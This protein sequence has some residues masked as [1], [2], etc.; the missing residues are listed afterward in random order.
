M[1][2]ESAELEVVAVGPIKV[3]IVPGIVTEPI[4]AT[5]RAGKYENARQ[6]CLRPMVEDGDRIVDIGG[7]IGFISTLMALEGRAERIVSIEGHPGAHSAAAITHRL[8]GV[9][10][11]RINA[12]A[13][14]ENTGGATR[15]LYLTE[16][17]WSS[18]MLP[19]AKG[20]DRVVEVPV[21]TFERVI[22]DHAPNMLVIDLEVMKEYLAPGAASGP[23]ESMALG[24]VDK[25]AVHFVRQYPG[26]E[27]AVPRVF[28]HFAAH[29]LHYNFDHSR[30][31]VVLFSR[32]TA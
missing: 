12:L 24:G 7:G 6:K 25:V 3:P 14:T 16:H 9:D 29:G 26:G 4:L 22:A 28:S 8:N 32:P 11:E 10:V 21:L 30:G 18:T 19:I 20:L 23:L 2:Q 15:P 5:L 31:S 27:T 17:F 13:V 1:A